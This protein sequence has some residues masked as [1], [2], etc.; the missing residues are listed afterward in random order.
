MGTSWRV[1]RCVACG[2][3]NW[4]QHFTPLH[5]YGGWGRGTSDRYCPECGYTGPTSDFPVV[6]ER[7][8]ADYQGQAAS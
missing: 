2:H 3:T 1:R 5:P 8:A 6:R 7:H 4:A